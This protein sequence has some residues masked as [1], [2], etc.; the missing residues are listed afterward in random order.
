MACRVTNVDP[1]RY[2]KSDQKIYYQGMNSLFAATPSPFAPLPST[3]E[4]PNGLVASYQDLRTGCRF[5]V[6]TPAA[7]RQLWEAYLLGA[8]RSYRKHDVESVLEYNEIRDGASTAIFFVALD[9]CGAV[10]GGMRLQGPY[11][12]TAQ[13]HAIAEWGSCDGAS[14]LHREI[15]ER[16]DDGVVEMK[17]GWVDDL[18]PGR[19]ALTDAMARM[20]V[21]ALT[22][23]NVRYVLGTVAKH[24]RRRWM[25]TGGVVSEDVAPVAYPDERYQT[26]PMWW[27]RET[28]ADL[29][30]A[31]Q[32]PHIV[33]E[34]AQLPV[35]A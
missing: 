31:D 19:S 32:L 35:A 1:N 21:H 30:D 29:A 15:T 5:V 8:Q 14:E 25:T 27:D 11:R 9:P 34:A 10:V 20:F 4:A 18:F 13:A 17:T 26:V 2:H 3:S 12:E 28:F 6:A 24:A 7:Q 33:F 22:L 23:M 16:L